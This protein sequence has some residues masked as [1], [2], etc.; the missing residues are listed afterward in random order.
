M[1]LRQA[2]LF[3]FCWRRGPGD[4]QFCDQLTATGLI[5]KLWCM[6]GTSMIISCS[7]FNKNGGLTRAWCNQWDDGQNDT[8]S[9]LQQTNSSMP[10]TSSFPALIAEFFSHPDNS[11]QDK[12]IQTD[13]GVDNRTSGRVEK[14]IRL[15]QRLTLH[16]PADFLLPASTGSTHKPLL[17]HIAQFSSKSNKAFVNVHS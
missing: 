13:F 8:A 1:Y 2:H 3:F 6:F 4:F 14:D 16:R 10:T 9:S 7:S 12:F 11:F 5:A 17:Y 15:T